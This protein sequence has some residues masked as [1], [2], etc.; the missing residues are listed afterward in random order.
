MPAA[1][2]A[3]APAGRAGGRGDAAPAGR[4]AA[5]PPVPTG[6][7]VAGE[8]KNFTRVTDEMLKNPPP[9]DWLVLRRDHYA[10]NFSPLTQITRDN[11][12]DLQLAW[13]WPMNEGGTNSRRRSPT[14][15]RSS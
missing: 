12:Q 7:T 14:T 10:S 11:A 1:V 9:G 4:G 5:P 6:V 15:A 13:V 3:A 8:V 2:R